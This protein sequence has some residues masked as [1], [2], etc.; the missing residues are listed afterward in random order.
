[1]AGHTLQHAARDQR[2]AGAGDDAGQHPV[3][4]LHL[5]DPARGRSVGMKP[6]LKMPAIGTVGAK[7]VDVG[8]VHFAGAGDGGVAVGGDDH[9]LFREHR[10]PLQARMH[11]RAVD[12]RG[13]QGALQ[14]AVDHRPGR[15]G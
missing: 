4:R 8:P 9:H 11:Q 14:Y 13:A 10:Q 6:A 5:V 1:M 15:A 12:K 7:G 2:Q 3:V